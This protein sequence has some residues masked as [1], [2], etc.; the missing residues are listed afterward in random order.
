M[1]DPPNLETA[2][3]FELHELEGSEATGR[4]AV[5]DTVRQP[6]GIVHGGAY[7]AMAE[8]LVSYATAAA[9][10]EEGM[11]AIGQANATSFLRPISEGTVH[12]SA[13]PRHRGRTTWVWDVELTGDDGRVA[14]VSRVTIA[15]RPGGG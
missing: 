12:A 7:A 10:R 1:T 4:F 14:A 15:V 13:T 3:G 11:I 6:Y 2:L 5:T 8:T 9:V